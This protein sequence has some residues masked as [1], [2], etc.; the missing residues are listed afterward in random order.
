MMSDLG[1]GIIVSLKDAFT[2][3]ATRIQSSMQSLDASVEAAGANMTRNLGFIEKGTMMI[4]AGLAMLAIPAGLVA[5]TAATQTALGEL[6]SVGVKDFRA[7][8]DAAEAFTNTWSGTC[9]AEFIAAAYD[10]KSALANLS[11]EAVGTFAAMAALTA[12]ATKAT[13]QEMVETFTTGYGIFKPLAKDMSDISWAR[14]F[15]GALAQTVAVF[16]TTGPQMAEAIKNIG[17]I[18]AASNVP[19]EEQMAILGQLQTTMPGSEAGTLYKAFMMQ[20]AKAGQE[21]GLSFVDARGQLKGIVPILQ[22]LKRGFPDLSNAAAQVKLKK[23]FGSDEA[24]RFLLQMSMGLDQLEGNIKSVGQAM[25]GGTA[26]TLEMARAMNMDIGSQYGLVRQQLQNLFEILGRTVL[27]VVIPVFQAFSRF[28]LHLQTLA[29]SMPGVTRAV[30]TLCAA[31]G[32]A[33]V[34]VGAVVS[35]I[36]TVGIVLPAVKA[37]I[38]AVGPMLAGV[39]SA[40]SAYFWPVVAIIAA[41]VVAVIALKRAWETNFAGIR[42]VVMGAWNKVSLAFQGIRAL[43]GSLSGGAGQMPA[44]LAQ[45]LQAAGLLKFVTTVFQVYYRVR[46]FLSGLW[47]AFS[48]CFGRIRA[49]LEPVVRK[50]MGAFGELGKALGSVF[51]AFG[52]ATT[53]ADASSFKSFGQT[54]GT[55]LGVIAQVAA[56]VMKLIIIPLSWVIRIVAAVVQGIVWF[57]KT[58][59]TAFV[60]AAPYVYRFS[61]PLRMI[62]QALLAVGR[63]AYAVWRMLSGDISVVDGLKAIGSAVYDFL[64]TPFQW[65]RDVASAAWGFLQSL[66][67]GLGGVFRSAGTTLL[68]F[69]Q[70]LPVVST[71]I[72]LFGSVRSLISGQINFAGAGERILVTLAQGMLSMLSLPVE[73]LRYAF[74][75]IIDAARSVWSGVTGIVSSG[76]NAVASIGSSAYAVVSAPFRWVAGVAGAAWSRA[77]AFASS[78]W[79]TVGSLASSVLGWLRNPFASLTSIASSAWSTIR[80]AASSTFSSILA[81]ARSLVA[82]AFQSGRSMMTTIA[83]GIRSAMSAPYEAAKSALSRLR[84]LL[85]FS[86]AREGPL[87]TLTRSGAA[88]LEAFSSGISRAAR[89]PTRAF[90]RALGLASQLSRNAVAPA[91]LAGTLAIT[92]TLAGAMPEIPSPRVAVQRGFGGNAL[93]D[94]SARGELLAATRGSLA[95]EPGAGPAT[96]SDNLRPLL[97]AILAKLDGLA[98]RPIDLSVTTNLDGRRVAQAVYKDMR[99]RKVRNYEPA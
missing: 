56:Y 76:W 80:S 74:S 20:V 61:L 42:D 9:K 55:L 93:S 81:G 2:Q 84:R 95:P 49:I 17:A 44:E 88:M 7:M 39:G 24:V 59:V 23:A 67:S 4:G 89:L 43:I 48:G 65:V 40:V 92:P 78:S 66:F 46:E 11:D 25:K 27:P 90:E 83:S 98:E 26:V 99:E 53:A 82:S 1:L 71:V 33:L 79:S 38:A 5:S 69:L 87:S 28:I 73:V 3:N 22:E 57:G 47:Q 70:S 35:A 19:L 13:T 97:E 51:A 30:L 86:D 91:A 60:A 63:V 75:L 64:A 15:S 50:L 72:K 18:A 52:L 8:E 36:G 41:V 96:N 68:S 94:R 37:G 12:K 16:K 32:A 58:V 29:K 45:K 85:P 62:V 54:L 10:V 21:L 6:A 34:V 77:T 31:L 14:M